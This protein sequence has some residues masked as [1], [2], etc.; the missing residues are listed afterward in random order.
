MITTS[1]REAQVG[2][3]SVSKRVTFRLT[4][5]YDRAVAK[6]LWEMSEALVGRRFD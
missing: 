4:N 5:I 2:H 6:K 3:F 1:S